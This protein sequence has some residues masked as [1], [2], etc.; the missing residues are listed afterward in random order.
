MVGAYFTSQFVNRHCQVIK[1][2]ISIWSLTPHN[3]EGI[4]NVV[5]SNNSASLSLSIKL[6]SIWHFLPKILVQRRQN[7]EFSWKS[8]N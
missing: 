5:A 4:L 2:H 3:D 6:I 8:K 1:N 7:I